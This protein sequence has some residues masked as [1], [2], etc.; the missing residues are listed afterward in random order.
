MAAHPPATQTVP[1]LS[2]T[3][4]TAAAAAPWRWW[5]RQ[6]QQQQQRDSRR[7]WNGSE[8]CT[9]GSA[10][11]ELFDATLPNAVPALVSS[12][13]PPCSCFCFC[14]GG[15]GA[16]SGPRSSGRSRNGSYAVETVPHAQHVTSD[17][18]SPWKTREMMLSRFAPA[19][20]GPAPPPA[21]IGFCICASARDITA[22]CQD[23]ITCF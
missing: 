15:A 17:R 14:S 5:Q 20:V 4:A 13:P 1:L 23:T 2:V 12:R 10:T 8:S 11:A 6:Q 22:Q 3:A 16:A 9:F 7:E 21:G 18:S 19:V